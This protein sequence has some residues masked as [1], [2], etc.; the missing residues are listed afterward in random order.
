MRISRRTKRALANLALFVGAL[1]LSL[2][3]VEVVLHL[4]HPDRELVSED[5][6]CEHDPMLGWRKIAGRKGWISHSE[7]GVFEE[8]NSKGIR[9]PEYSYEKPANEFR[10]LALGDSFSEGY[11]VSFDKLFSE[12]LKG[13]LNRRGDGRDYQ[14]INTGT[15]AYSTDQELLFFELEGR[16]YSPDLVVLMFCENDL[17]YNTQP[18]Y[19][20]TI[21]NDNRRYDKPVFRFED[22]VLHLEN[23]PVPQ[24]D[25]PRMFSGV[26]RIRL[27][28]WLASKSFIC[29]FLVGL[30]ERASF[31]SPGHQE[32]G[33]AENRDDRDVQAQ[34]G[35]FCILMGMPRTPE[36]QPAWDV[37]E[38]LLCRLRDDVER[39]AGKLIVFYVPTR[40]SIC[41]T[42]GDEAKPLEAAT[43][44]GWDI[45]KVAK[46][47][48]SVCERQSIPLISPTE[49]FRTKAAELKERG[50]R[51]YN[52]LDAHW[53]EKGHELAGQ[54]LSE[55]I[56]ANILSRDNRK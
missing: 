18:R 33:T 2:A 27:I 15:R 28:S 37:T 46:D 49:E 54:I 51:L 55:Y 13:N 30:L 42:S 47:L 21:G 17:W 12:R 1:A 50:A 56:Q 31:L 39:S 4:M 25:M 10:I 24:P 52:V 14:V 23:V 29:D 43:D 45:E 26:R 11:T 22:G 16:K 53:T 32:L 44:A 7:F 6:F 36:V 35:R 34:M 48:A 5:C 9:G 8:I 20:A 38:A 3:L 40:E 41:G 19:L